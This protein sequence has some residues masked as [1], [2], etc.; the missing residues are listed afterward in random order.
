M[1]EKIEI[2]LS[3]K[4]VYLGIC[5]SLLFVIAGTWLFLNANE[6]QNISLA[7]LRNPIVIKGIGITGILFFGATGVYGFIKLFDQKAGLVLDSDGITD[8]TNASSVGLIR[9]HDITSIKTEQVMSTK[10]LLIEVVNPESYI[11]KS[12]SRM[13]ARLMRT[14]MKMYGTPLS[15]TSSSL[16]FN[17]GELER[18]IQTEFKKNK[19]AR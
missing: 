9:W 6:F 5:G 12:K 7:F 18:L 1:D 10:F 8:N 17:F 16:N 3:Q 15:I 13:K 11:E 4:K 2:S 19:N 14:N